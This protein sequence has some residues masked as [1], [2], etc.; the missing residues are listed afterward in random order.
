VEKKNINME[1]SALQSE[2]EHAPPHTAV[3]YAVPLFIVTGVPN[4][5]L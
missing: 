4:V 3:A 2:D 5:T 1:E